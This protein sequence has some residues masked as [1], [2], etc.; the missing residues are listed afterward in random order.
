MSIKY[1]SND[2][3]EQ[4]IERIIK[5]KQRRTGKKLSSQKVRDLK[6][7]ITK[8]EMQKDINNLHKISKFVLEKLKNYRDNERYEMT[9][10][11]FSE[12]KEN[13]EKIAQKLNLKLEDD[14]N[15]MQPT[16][17]KDDFTGLNFRKYEQEK[18]DSQ[19]IEDMESILKATK[20]TYKPA[21]KRESEEI[22]NELEGKN[23][24]TKFLERSLGDPWRIQQKQL[25]NVLGILNR[26]FLEYQ[27]FEHAISDKLYHQDPD[28][29]DLEDVLDAMYSGLSH[30]GGWGMAY[31]AVLTPEK[32]K[33]REVTKGKST[34]KKPSPFSTKPS[35]E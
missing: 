25:Q 31:R 22:Q 20:E 8:K 3:L 4:K 29:A 23:V 28:K 30:N 33:E 24:N 15:K 21:D 35:L 32:E 26:W 16:K 6:T 17:I 1:T 14:Q 18:W 10:K 27:N 34:R 5:E 7:R 2:T 11:H 19:T 9:K 12:I 13:L